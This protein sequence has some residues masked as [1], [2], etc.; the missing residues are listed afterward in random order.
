MSQFPRTLRRLLMLG[1]VV[2]LLGMSPLAAGCSESPGASSVDGDVQVIEVSADGWF[3]PA[4][5][6]RAGSPIRL[7]FGPGSG[8][9]AAVTVAGLTPLEDLTDGGGT[10]NLPGLKPGR[11]PLKCQADMF[12]G[13]LVVE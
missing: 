2:L 11:Y 9:T 5:A 4:T 8:C 6:A 13:E 12:M 1:A 7:E 10:L 3:T